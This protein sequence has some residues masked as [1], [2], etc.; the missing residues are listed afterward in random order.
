MDNIPLKMGIIFTPLK[1]YRDFPPIGGFFCLFS[2]H[3]DNTFGMA[4]VTYRHE[5]N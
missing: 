5:L 3:M 2:T 1:F 4:L